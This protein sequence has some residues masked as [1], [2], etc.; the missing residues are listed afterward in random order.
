MGNGELRVDS[1]TLRRAA[2]DLDQAVDQLDAH[3]TALENELAGFGAPWG[4]DEIGM[5]IQDAYE[6]IVDIAMNCFNSNIEELESVLAGLEN[7]AAQYEA[8]ERNSVVEVN[9]VR[10]FL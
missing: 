1:G 6:S 4:S 10:E 9:R 2:R 5:L 7:M 3:L 8:A